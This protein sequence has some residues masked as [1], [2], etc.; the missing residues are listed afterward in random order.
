MEDVRKEIK[1]I[2]QQLTQYKDGFV[3]QDGLPPIH[4]GSFCAL[5][6]GEKVNKNGRMT[7]SKKN[8]L[9]YRDVAKLILQEM[10]KNT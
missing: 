1:E 7:G 9:K 2:I 6:D 3:C 10:K 5:F 4:I 8:I